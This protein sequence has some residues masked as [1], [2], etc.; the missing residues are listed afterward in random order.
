[1]AIEQENKDETVD[2]ILRARQL[3]ILRSAGIQ[4]V[5]ERLSHLLATGK[6]AAS[7]VLRGHSRLL[8]DLQSPAVPPAANEASQP[9]TD[10][11]C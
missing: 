5:D 11:V 9:Q 7:Q 3:R 4:Q 2:E 1:M 6:I 10:E 8:H